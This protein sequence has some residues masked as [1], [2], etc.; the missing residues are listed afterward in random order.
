MNR[1]ILQQPAIP[2]CDYVYFA[3][4]SRAPFTI[5]S[6][7]VA[8]HKLIIA[9]A[10]NSAGLRMPLVPHLQPG[11]TILLAYGSGTYAPV[12]RCAIVASPNP[13]RTDNHVFEVFCE[14][15]HSLHQQLAHANYDPDPVAKT[16]I[17]I[18]IDLLQ[19]LRNVKEV[20]VKP[21][22]NNTLRRWE[23]VFRIEEV[24][25]KPFRTR[26]RELSLERSVLA[27]PTGTAKSLGASVLADARR[28]ILRIL[29]GLEKE[30]RAT[31]QSISARIAQLSRIGAIPRPIAACMRTVTEMRNAA[32][33]DGRDL[34]P[35]ESSAVLG[36]WSAINEWATIYGF[37][38]PQLQ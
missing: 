31:D 26:S 5:T 11:E 18:S 7:F 13:V 25:S 35:A 34:S 8:K 3:T 37:P 23:E 32:E 29:D 10:H 14:I 4:P 30:G 17:G 22:G 15:D 9:R 6:E 38:L 33:Y 36:A 20:I 28:C 19:D 1:D 16:F 2:R 27:P 21:K 12:F 24:N